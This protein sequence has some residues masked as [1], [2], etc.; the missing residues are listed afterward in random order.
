M[1]CFIVQGTLLFVLVS[2]LL[3]GCNGF[4]VKNAQ[5]SIE[6]EHTPLDKSPRVSKP[7]QQE[8]DIDT[9]QT[10]NPNER[11]PLIFQRTQ[12]HALYPFAPVTISK[13]IEKLP[14]AE[15]KSRLAKLKKSG[16]YS[17]FEYEET[18]WEGMDSVYEE[19][20]GTLRYA[21]YYCYE[22]RPY[23]AYP[24]AA[25]ALAA[26]PNDFEALLTWVY[27]YQ[28]NRESHNRFDDAER[29]IA[30]RRLQ[31]MHPNH[32]YVLQELA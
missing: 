31:N 1:K 19:A 15:I 10:L 29:V 26:N 22:G 2:I 24:F 4:S 5:K 9:E 3:V 32:P 6:P 27:T 28:H 7:T 16:D 23:R 20:L 21:Q 12:G 11:S 25:K 17:E 30:L 8:V 18:I 14:D 13:G